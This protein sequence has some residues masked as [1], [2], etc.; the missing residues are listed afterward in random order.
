[1]TNPYEVAAEFA[2]LFSRFEH[3]L[4]RTHFLRNCKD[5]QADWNKF[6]RELGPDFFID[7]VNSNMASTLIADPP[8]KL[9]KDDL[10]WK[11]EK[12][13]PLKNVIELFELGVCRV[14]NSYIHGEK[15]VGSAGPWERDVALVTEAYFVLREA[16]T[17]VPRVA[18][19]LLA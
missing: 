10:K 16:Q 18:A 11:P 19:I 3:A 12:T 8:R 6:A 14:R 15:F 7:M 4:K 1:M 13:T 2:K 9:M 5:A 17:R